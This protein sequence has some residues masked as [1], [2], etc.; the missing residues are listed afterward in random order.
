M[1]RLGP[2]LRDCFRKQQLAVQQKMRCSTWLWISHFTLIA[3][4]EWQHE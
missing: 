4:S 1:I 3:S 2:E